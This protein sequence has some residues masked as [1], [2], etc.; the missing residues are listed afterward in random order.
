MLIITL[1][2]SVVH[3][4]PGNCGG[5]KAVGGASVTSCLLMRDSVLGS[6]INTKY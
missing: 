4:A 2:R 1:K 6:N 3:I 5:T